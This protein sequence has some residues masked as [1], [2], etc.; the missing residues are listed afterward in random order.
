MF[1]MVGLPA[2]NNFRFEKFP[3]LELHLALWS[4]CRIK[5]RLA[6]FQNRFTRVLIVGD[7]TEIKLSN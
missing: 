6:T 4:F 1:T 2:K 5:F 3:S 7:K